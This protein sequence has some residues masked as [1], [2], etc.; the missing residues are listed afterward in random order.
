MNRLKVILFFILFGLCGKAQT[1][2]EF[3]E[4]FAKLAANEFPGSGVDGLFHRYANLLYFFNPNAQLAADLK[5]NNFG[6]YP[7]V[8]FKNKPLYQQHIIYLLTDTS[9]Q[10]NQL[11]CMLAAASLDRE[12]T[13]LIESLVIKNHYED[14]WAVS[15][16]MVLK[17]KNLQPAVKTMAKLANLPIGSYLVPMFLKLDATVL[18]KFATD[19]LSSRNSPIRYLAI[20][21]AAIGE[22][23]ALKRQKLQ[24]IVVGQDALKGWAISV[25]AA[26]NSPGMSKYVRSYLSDPGLRAVSLRALANSPSP[27]DQQLLDSVIGSKLPDL[28]L[29]EALKQSSGTTAQ[30][31]WLKLLRSDSIPE[32]YLATIDQT[33]IESND[34]IAPDV[35]STLLARLADKRI[36]PLVMYFASRKDD[37]T[38][39]FLLH[40]M[41]A[42]GLD[43]RNQIAIAKNL[44]GRNPMLINSA[45]AELMKKATPKD[46]TLV[47]LLMSYKIYTYRDQVTQWLNDPQLEHYY[48][49]V[50]KQYLKDSEK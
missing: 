16:L 2:A 43:E 14:F 27:F 42:P 20:R 21:A 49:A 15:A 31:R 9:S 50:C 47:E 45:V 48:I 8:H 7:L 18:H 34:L 26:A 5:G 33:K 24:Q 22:M 32:D 19:S 41:A 35:Q 28:E 4:D 44:T 38:T 46:A 17:T 10:K 29:L 23:T 12:K 30:R 25:L 11:G 36:S 37:A 1:P 6:D 3:E 39:A 13:T 40:V